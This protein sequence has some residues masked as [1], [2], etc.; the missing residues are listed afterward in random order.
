MPWY[1]NKVV[2]KALLHSCVCVHQHMN[3]RRQ[4]VFLM[5][6]NNRV[7]L[8][9]LMTSSSNQTETFDWS[10]GQK[11]WAV[12]CLSTSQWWSWLWL[13]STQVYL[14]EPANRAHQPEGRWED[15]K[16]ES[17]FIRINWSFNGMPGL[18]ALS[19]CDVMNYCVFNRDFLK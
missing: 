12:S 9:S 8:F 7:V 2:I 1:H 14:H 3:N 18:C 6:R 15:T 10:W 17:V 13:S 4:E 5:S 19:Q 16:E 11:L